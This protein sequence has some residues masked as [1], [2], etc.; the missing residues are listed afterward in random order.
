[1]E[2]AICSQKAAKSGSL[3]SVSMTDAAAELS[4]AAATV[5]L[6]WGGGCDGGLGLFRF[7]LLNGVTA[8]LTL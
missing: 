3:G 7:P 5:P 1:M 6:G 8:A 2:A 4:A